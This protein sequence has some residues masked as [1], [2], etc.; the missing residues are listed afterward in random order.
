MEGDFRLLAVKFPRKST[1]FPLSAEGGG[2][3]LSL[4]ES[5]TSGCG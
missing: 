2:P 3:Q 5:P 4:Y 1:H